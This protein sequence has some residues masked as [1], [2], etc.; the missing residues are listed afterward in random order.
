[1]NP[2]RQE[3][4]RKLIDK[5]S[6]ILLDEHENIFGS[7]AFNKLRQQAYEECGIWINGLII[8]VNLNEGEMSISFDLMETV[9]DEELAGSDQNKTLFKITTEDLEFAKTMHVKLN[10]KDAAEIEGTYAGLANLNTNA[11]EANSA[12]DS[13]NSVDTRNVDE[14]IESLKILAQKLNLNS[15]S[16][17][18]NTFNTNS[19]WSQLGVRFSD[20]DNERLGDDIHWLIKIQEIINNIR[21]NMKSAEDVKK[22]L[23]LFEKLM[24]IMLESQED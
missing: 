23:I 9:P 4:L 10:D 15:R 3:R 7:E 8:T 16:D 21:K 17:L 24:N 6:Q 14:I 13:I 18:A 1:M 19:T 22:L 5:I 11:S 12:T 20:S 2:Q